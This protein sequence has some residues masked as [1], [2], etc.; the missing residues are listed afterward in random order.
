MNTRLQYSIIF[1]LLLLIIFSIGYYI[2]GQNNAIIPNQNIA[3]TIITVPSIT[4]TISISP[5]VSPAQIEDNP[6]RIDN[7]DNPGENNRRRSGKDK[8]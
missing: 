3:P 6:E 7:D 8:D 2:R 4:P 5:T 1:I